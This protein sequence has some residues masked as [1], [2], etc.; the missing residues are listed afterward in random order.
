[1]R[2]QRRLHSRQSSRRLIAKLGSYLTAS[3]LIKRSQRGTEL[4]STDTSRC[5]P[6]VLLNAHLKVDSILVNNI[7]LCLLAN[8]C[9]KVLCSFTN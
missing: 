4:R 8:S 1:M 2:I 6:R 5:I 9:F 3:G 7:S